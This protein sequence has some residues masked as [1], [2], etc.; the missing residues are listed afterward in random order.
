MMLSFRIAAVALIAMSVFAGCAAPAEEDE[1]VSET[2]AAFSA[3]SPITLQNFATHPK[4]VEIQKIVDDFENHSERYTVQTRDADLCG[5]RIGDTYRRTYSDGKIVRRLVLA[6]ATNDAGETYSTV[7][8]RV[9]TYDAQGRVRTALTQVD[10]ESGT[11]Q[12]R[13]YFGT[14]GTRLIDLQ[15]RQS[16]GNASHPEYAPYT[17]ASTPATYGNELTA[18]AAAFAAAPKCP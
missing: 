11:T 1:P 15:R 13:T 2:G 8:Q 10:K 14:D 16:G 7:T 12:F 17:L 18:P 9:L 6:T 3:S 5:S 4:I